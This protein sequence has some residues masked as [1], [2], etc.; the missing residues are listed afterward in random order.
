MKRTKKEIAG[1]LVDGLW[2]QYVERVPY[3]KLYAD[4]EPAK[5]AKL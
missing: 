5:E 1:L 4:M 2:K 3:A